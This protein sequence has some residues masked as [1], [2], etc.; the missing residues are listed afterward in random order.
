MYSNTQS[1]NNPFLQNNRRN[2]RQIQRPPLPLQRNLIKSKNKEIIDLSIE[3][4]P[5][6][7]TITRSENI[8]TECLDYTKLQIESQKELIIPTKNTIPPGWLVIS[9]ENNKIVKKYNPSSNEKT[10]RNIQKTPEQE[11][12]QTYEILSNHWN[13][14][15][16]QINDLL[17]DQSEYW[18]YKNKINAI[19]KEEISILIQIDEKHN[20]SNSDNEEELYN[21]STDNY[22]FY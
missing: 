4:F 14:Y 1:G 2:N 16:D 20:I 11:T 15:R 17:G 8:K 5:T 13:N 3:A 12:M 18:N 19:Y 21:E 22:D 9:R 7:N 10:K 6:L